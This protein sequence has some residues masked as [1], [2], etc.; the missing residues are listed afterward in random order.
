MQKLP[1]SF[2]KK[3]GLLITG[4]EKT[5]SGE[6]L[7]KIAYCRKPST[8][9]LLELRRYLDLPLRLE[10]ISDEQFN[11]LL[12]KLY[13][14]DTNTAMQMAEDFGEELGGRDLVAR[15]HDGVVEG[16][17]HGCHPAQ[18]IGWGAQI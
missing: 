6:D 14:T 3:A 11:Q 16:D 13:E 2:A 5:V 10:A 18:A 8:A 7:A 15:R 9:H 1:F 12:V 4:V 17:R